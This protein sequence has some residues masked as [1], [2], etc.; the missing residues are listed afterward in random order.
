MTTDKKQCYEK[1]MK[2]IRSINYKREH[3][4]PLNTEEMEFVLE[5]YRILCPLEY[6]LTAFLFALFIAVIL[7]I[8]W[9][10]LS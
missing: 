7:W 9:A 3:G 4:E 8:I 6:E 2:L 10:I 5:T 1:T